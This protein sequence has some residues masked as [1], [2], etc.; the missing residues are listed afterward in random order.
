MSE[1]V[2]VGTPGA[3]KRTVAVWVAVGALVLGVTG[4]IIAVTLNQGSAGGP[5]GSA[6]PMPTPSVTA[7]PAPAAD[8][9]EVGELDET[10]ATDVIVTALAAPISTATTP[11]D[12]EA[13]LKNVATDAYAAELEA[14]WLEL[15]SQGWTV[16]GSPDLVSTAVTALDT[17]AAVPTAQV[18][19]CLD[20][21][22]VVIAD[23]AGDPIGDV[24]AM[25]PRALHLFT[26]LQGDDGVWRISSHTFPNDPTC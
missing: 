26:L 5:D 23:Y 25:T 17:D 24:S 4:A 16:S 8:P 22:A 11:G 13:L 14:Q 6:T 18:T 3:R 20:S 15:N 7:T 2:S 1:D 12:L 9:T 19:A 10:V 21:S